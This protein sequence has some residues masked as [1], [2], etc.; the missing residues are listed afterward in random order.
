MITHEDLNKLYPLMV[1]HYQIIENS[2]TLNQSID[3]FE[4]DTSSLLNL[5]KVL[6][7]LKWL[8]HGYDYLTFKISMDQKGNL[9]GM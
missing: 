7:S 5:L 8:I 9:G 1:D 4:G 6:L 3:P 2:I